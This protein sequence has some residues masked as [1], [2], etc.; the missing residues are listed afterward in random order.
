MSSQRQDAER[1]IAVQAEV[2]ALKRKAAAWGANEDEETISA[3]IGRWEALANWF[4]SAVFYEGE[5][6]P[7]V[8]HAFQAAKAGADAVAAKA[9]RE[10]ATPK[11]A[12]EL[13]RKLPLPVDWERRKRPLM[14]A[15]LRDKFR[16]DS[17][18]H[19]RL[20]RTD[21][22]NLIAGNDWGETFWGVSGGR[23]ANELGKAL[24]AVRDEARA[25][26]DLEAWLAAAF[27]LA[28]AEDAD[29][30]LALQVHK[31]GALVESLPLGTASKALVGK[32]SSCDVQLDHPSISRRHAAIVRHQDGRLLLV[33]LASKAGVTLDGKRVPPLVGVRLSQGS[34]IVFGG[35]SRSHLVQLENIDVLSRLEAQRAALQ[36]EIATLEA[37]AGD[38]T[39]LYGLLPAEKR[40]DSNKTCCYL[41]NMPFDATAQGL[42]E[43][44]STKGFHVAPS[45]CRLPTDKATGEPRG[46]AFV[47]FGDA[48][49]AF[50][51]SKA[52]HDEVFEGRSVKA[53]VAQGS[54]GGGKGG[55][56]KGGG[57]KGA[58]D[59]GAG[60][61]GAGG[62]GGAYGGVSG[63]GTSGAGRGVS[64]VM[65]GS[66]GG[67]RGDSAHH[68][69]HRFV[70]HHLSSG[71]GGGG[72][73]CGGGG[74]YDE[75]RRDRHEEDERR[76]D[77]HED[78]ERRHR[79]DRDR[80]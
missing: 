51:A 32:H 13:G 57:G 10:A 15:L 3:F 11:L 34:T 47:E 60:S 46:F 62:K 68:S 48:Q 40:L 77:R 21:N 36:H 61:Y 30:T 53:D 71:G 37:E 52:L 26:T 49:A 63:S 76:R 27:P 59:R 33:D 18:L 67:G 25:G 7:S 5:R 38:A 80:D 42:S 23:G 22:R 58:G 78:D 2:I 70:T 44:L 20:L 28:R 17:A 72:G 16:R 66:T 1:L 45:A 41:G 54:G 9:I 31:G 74:G 69:A 6:Y 79:R 12:H 50:A 24:M 8:E 29:A 14:Q 35:S 65:G 4:Q 55:G 19:E 73:G 56:G 64:A 39:C 43:W 75:G